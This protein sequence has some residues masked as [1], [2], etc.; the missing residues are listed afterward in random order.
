MDRKLYYRA[1]F[2]FNKL[3][4]SEKL[5]G[6][7]NRPPPPP[8]PRCSPKIFWPMWNRVKITQ[9]IEISQK[10]LAHFFSQYF[11]RSKQT[12][13]AKC[14]ESSWLTSGGWFLC[15]GSWVHL[16]N[17]I[18]TKWNFDTTKGNTHF[19]NKKLR[20]GP[21]TESFLAFGNLEYSKFLN[22]FLTFS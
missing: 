16:V 8:F 20:S 7:Q 9:N 21:S 19:F 12:F 22:S 11:I 13:G 17:C 1:K 10:S 2:G 3:T 5:Q 15:D 4:N 14:S 6:W 18:P